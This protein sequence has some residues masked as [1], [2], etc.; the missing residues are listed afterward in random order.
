MSKSGKMG[1]MVRS[2]STCRLIDQLI[3]TSIIVTPL[4]MCFEVYMYMYLYFISRLGFAIYTV[5]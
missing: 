3:P 2:V 1:K 4:C 5:P